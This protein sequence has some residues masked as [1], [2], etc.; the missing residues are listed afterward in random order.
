MQCVQATAK[1]ID[2]QLSKLKAVRDANDP[3]V[4]GQPLPTYFK[5]PFTEALDLVGTRRVYI[6]AGT[7]YVPFEHVVSILFAAFRA[8][9][10]P[11]LLTIVRGSCRD[12]LTYVYSCCVSCRKNCRALFASTIGR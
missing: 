8:N 2:A 9:V 10:R 1:E 6:E 7:A 12:I 3:K 11:A 5:V 4:R